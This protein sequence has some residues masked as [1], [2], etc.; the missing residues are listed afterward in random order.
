MQLDETNVRFYL[1][2]SPA[3]PSLPLIDQVID[4]DSI[5]QEL[6]GFRL[7]LDDYIE[8]VFAICQILEI[9]QCFQ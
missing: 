5:W 3:Y 9:A 6:L 7:R 4:V 1:C 2:C 8:N